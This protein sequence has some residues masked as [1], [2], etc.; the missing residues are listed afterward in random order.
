MTGPIHTYGPSCLLVDEPRQTDSESSSPPEIR[1]HFFYISTLPIDDPLAPLPP[2]VNQAIGTE[3]L[4]PKPF[5]A[6]DNIALE[7]AW[8]DLGGAK[9]TQNAPSSKPKPNVSDR[10]SGIA[11][12]GHGSKTNVEARGKGERRKDPTLVD[13]R[14]STLSNPSSVLDELP[15]QSHRSHVAFAS[16]NAGVPA[17]GIANGDHEDSSSDDEMTH[18][19]PKSILIDRKKVRSSSFNQSSAG[20]RRSVSPPVAEHVDDAEGAGSL[21]HSRSRDASISGSP[22]IRAPISQSQTPLGRSFK[23]KSSKEGGQEWQ[24][25]VRNSAPRSAP[26]PSG[27]R[28]TV[29]LDQLTQDSQA[30]R[31]EESNTQAKIPVGVSR[32]HLVE[33]PNLKVGISSSFGHACNEPFFR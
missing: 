16:S 23:S 12:P 11:V 31:N 6:R 4:P 18:A 3:R 29:S 15:T 27:L 14:G 26:K 9:K 5:S 28:A 8:R 13:S 17:R 10:P 2:P 19:N 24:A 1:T 25:D 33:L 22:F 30:E 7:K 32:L 21:P 20:S